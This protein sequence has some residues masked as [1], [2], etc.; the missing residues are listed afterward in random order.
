MGTARTTPSAPHDRRVIAVPRPA[1]LN[2][3]PPRVRL[4]NLRDRTS[5]VLDGFECQLRAERVKEVRAV[6]RAAEDAAR[7]GRW[8]AGYVSYEAA[9]GFDRGLDVFAGDHAAPAG[10]PL[11][12]FGIFRECRVGPLSLPRG[13]RGAS[14][15]W[16]LAT[17][18]EE[19]SLRVKTILDEIEAGNAYQVNLTGPVTCPDAGDHRA[20]YRRLLLAQQPGH[21]ALIELDGAAI[22]S[23]SPELF[24][25]WAGG[26][27][28]S[29]PMKGTARRGR[30]PAEDAARASGLA[31]SAKERAENVMIVD[32]IRNDLGKVAAVGSV[33]VTSLCELEGYPHV[34]Q[35][36]SEVR[37]ETRP[38]VGV[39]DIFDAMFPCGSVTGTPKQSAMGII[40]R[41]ESGPRG[42]YCGAVGM[43]APAPGGVSARFNVAIRTA[44]VDQST[45]ATSFGSGGG[46]VADSMPES[47]YRELLLKADMLDSPLGAPFRL[48]ETFRYSPGAVNPNIERHLARLKG[49]AQF[50]GFA[51]PRDLESRLFA[52]LAGRNTDSRVRLL[53]ARGGRVKVELSD[54]PATQS[55]PLSLVIDAEP[56]WSQ[57]SLLFHKTTRRGPY[58]RRRRRH[59]G[60]DD[61]VLVNERGECTEVTTANLAMRRGSAWLTPPLA[62]GCLPGIERS[63]LVEEGVLVEATIRPA[64][65]HAADEI[66]V[67]NSLRGWR[68][69]VL[70]CVE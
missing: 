70:R 18:P 8:A 14:A 20:L 25:D 22:L 26:E 6:V 60:A 3:S 53:L 68:R 47:E 52:K 33:A 49:S 40:R 39:V 54:A 27:L 7:E 10:P 46:I 21:G 64:D 13:A 41:L 59:P 29:R 32:L 37:C 4:D 16:S 1:A 42:V 61:V 2:D 30:W 63:R 58:E 34:W 67:V 65:L 50:L 48:L 23:A 19:Y 38:E 69:A 9:P 28:R 62:A 5:T 56:V 45:G 11:A 35:M 51:V 31:G 36:V 12:W 24:F 66:A 15:R 17:A 43:I 55:E 57:S 44:V